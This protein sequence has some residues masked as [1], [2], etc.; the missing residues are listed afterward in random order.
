MDKLRMQ[1][2]NGVNANIER[3]A[4]LF[5]DCVTETSQHGTTRWAADFD[6]LRNALTADLG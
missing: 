2:A 5:P 3:L 6:K 4:E 1:T